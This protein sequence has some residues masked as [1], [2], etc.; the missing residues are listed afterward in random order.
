[1]NNIISTDHRARQG[2]TP[3]IQDNLSDQQSYQRPG[4]QQP[5]LGSEQ[6]AF[7]K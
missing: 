7:Y 3:P 4:T 6:T 5:D 1:M 2:K